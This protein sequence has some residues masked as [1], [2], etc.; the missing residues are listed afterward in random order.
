MVA[1]YT[2]ACLVILRFTPAACDAALDTIYLTKR[3]RSDIESVA[4]IHYPE[5]PEVFRSS[6]QRYAESHCQC[7]MLTTRQRPAMFDVSVY[8]VLIDMSELNALN[9]SLQYF[10]RNLKLLLQGVALDGEKV[11]DLYTLKDNLGG[12]VDDYLHGFELF[13]LDKV[14]ESTQLMPVC[15]GS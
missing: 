10:M 11:A 9:Y 2:G 7:T 13:L 4:N 15:Q 14:R 6:I 8:W 3:L 5:R 1:I 12:A